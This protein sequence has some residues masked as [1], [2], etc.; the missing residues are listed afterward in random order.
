MGHGIATISTLIFGIMGLLF[1]ASNYA[2]QHPTIVLVPNVSETQAEGIAINDV[3]SRLGPV[4][5]FHLWASGTGEAGYMNLT[6]FRAG[7]HHLSMV[8]AHPNGTVFL[9]NPTDYTIHQKCNTDAMCVNS[10]VYAIVEGRLAY[11]VDIS[12]SNPGGSDFLYIDAANGKILSR[13]SDPI[14]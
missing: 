14:R 12:W 7:H 9:V 11:A 2:N 13:A 6:S 3:T 1:F 8:F 10:N 4:R 5:D